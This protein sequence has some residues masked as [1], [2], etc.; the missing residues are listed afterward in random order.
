MKIL[1]V[2][3][4][5][6][7]IRPGGAEGY[8]FEVYEGMRDPGEFEPVF[9]ARSGPPFSIATAH[10]EGRPFTLTNDDPNQYLFYTDPRASTGCTGARA[11]VRADTLLQRVP[12]RPAARRRALPPHDVP[13][14]RHPARDAQ[15][16]ARRADRLHAHDHMPICHRDGQMVRTHRK[17]ALPPS[18]RRCHECFPGISQQ[19][20]SCA[21]A[22]SSRS[23]PRRPLHRPPARSRSS[24]TSTGE[25][26][27]STSCSS[28]M[29]ARRW[30]TAGRRR[31]P[32]RATGSDSSAS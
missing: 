31:G 25:F 20:S 28:R 17:L 23:S 13:R 27:A 30:S 16:A 11:K 3:H 8:A 2:C 21:S 32:R 9:L 7:A 4:N 5:H 1:F 24:A 6:P 26:R 29:A 22:S 19:T 14:L 10:H 15:H 12:A 18:P